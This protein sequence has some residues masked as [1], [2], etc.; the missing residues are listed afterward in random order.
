MKHKLC[1]LLPSLEV[2]G[3]E[4]IWSELV[5][6]L[7]LYEVT[8]FVLSERI[9]P[10]LEEKINRRFCIVRIKILRRN[11]FATYLLS[12]IDLSAFD[13]IHCVDRFTLAASA[14][15]KRKLGAVVTMGIYHSREMLWRHPSY[16]SKYQE[17]LFRSLP[18]ENI[19]FGNDDVSD[20][21]SSK[22]K[23]DIP[24]S[25][26]FIAGVSLLR[27]LER[28]SDLKFHIGIVGRHTSF[29]S[30][31]EAALKI[32]QSD[33]FSVTKPL[34]V[35]LIGEGPLTGKFK[36][37]FPDADFCGTLSIQELEDILPEFDF[38]LCGGTSAPLIASTGTPVLVGIENQITPM[39]SGFF[40]E[41]AHD[42]YNLVLG[43]NRGMRLR[44]KISSFYSGDYNTQEMSVASVASS[45]RFSFEIFSKKFSI[46]L[47]SAKPS[48]PR[49]M[50]IEKILYR[51]SLFYWLILDVIGFDKSIRDRYKK[52]VDKRFFS[53]DEKF[54]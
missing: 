41:I 7:E 32:W 46:F 38:V 45:E 37:A 39:V 17:I 9:D 44:Q 2:G 21:Y 26:I 3:V 19:Y 5:K 13:M 16:F 36:R 11:F 50:R 10:F 52:M 35:T 49:V 48:E 14:F 29:K 47:G 51:L 33:N 15:A 40:H 1:V 23:H 34:K 6:T 24:E 53:S 25:S 43:S 42:N 18:S 4:L 22:F 30:Y 27:P 12:H 8:L 31:I 54:D 20:N 28:S